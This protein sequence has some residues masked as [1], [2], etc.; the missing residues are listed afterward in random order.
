MNATAYELLSAIAKYWFIA[1]ALFILARMVLSVTREIRI[2]RQVQA[3]IG[4]AGTGINATLVLLSDEDRRLKRGKR[5][6]VQ[7]ETTVGRAGRCDVT[8]H[9]RSLE[10]VHCILNMERDGM[11][12]VPVG[13]AFVVVDGKVVQ[14]RATAQDG[15]EIQM[16]GLVFR[17]RLEETDDAE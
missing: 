9:T 2:E 11:S 3:E 6:P 4:Q 13:R 8:L 10:R 16:G 17:L 14:R 5:Y 15:S 7:G 12:V 1:L